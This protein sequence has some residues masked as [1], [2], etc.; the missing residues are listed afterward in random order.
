MGSAAAHEELAE[1]S[2]NGADPE[3]QMYQCWEMVISVLQTD[4]MRCVVQGMT[5]DQLLPGRQQMRRPLQSL[6]RSG[7][8]K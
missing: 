3:G 5:S 6:P 4:A 8:R 7:R 1:L 2:L